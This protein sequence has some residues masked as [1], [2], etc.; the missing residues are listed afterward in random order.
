VTTAFVAVALQV[1]D[2]LRLW[3]SA[4]CHDRVST[5]LS[6]HYSDRASHKW[7]GIHTQTSSLRCSD[8][9]IG[10]TRTL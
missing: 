7:Q 5:E 10:R 1:V 9:R 3:N 8:G 2:D 6:C 4:S